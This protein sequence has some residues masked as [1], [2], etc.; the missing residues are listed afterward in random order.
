MYTPEG[1]GPFPTLVYLHGGG[2]VIGSLDTADGI[3]RVLADEA[4]CVVV[5]VDYRLAP[6]YP[7][8]AGLEDGTAA[9]EWVAVDPDERTERR[10]FRR[11]P[12]IRVRR[13]ANRTTQTSPFDRRSTEHYRRS[14]VIS[15]GNSSMLSPPDLGRKYCFH[16]RLSGSA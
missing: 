3:Y 6:E 5:S 9:T 4:D 16:S 10:G 7:F 8:P 2:W 12:A 15:N 14:V 13:R 11:R 1:T